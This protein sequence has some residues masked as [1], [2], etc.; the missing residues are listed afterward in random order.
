MAK[1]F[2]QRESRQPCS[3]V[4]EQPDC[5]MQEAGEAASKSS[6]LAQTT[7]PLT[8]F[9]NFFRL[10]DR[11]QNGNHVL[12]N[13]AAA[14]RLPGVLAGAL[15][16]HR[17]FA[18]S[19]QGIFHL[20]SNSGIVLLP[21]EERAGMQNCGPPSQKVM[22][23]IKLFICKIGPSSAAGRQLAPRIPGC[24]KH[25]YRQ[26]APLPLPGAAI[27]PEAPAPRT[28]RSVF[29]TRQPEAATFKMWSMRKR[30]TEERR[31][32]S[33]AL[34]SMAAS[35]AKVTGLQEI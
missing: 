20:A 7:K 27:R 12:R 34:F 33:K 29:M 19:S 15:R 13:P 17:P 3:R 14:E 21:N 18:L 30:S 11:K 2:W 31:R 32:N 6:P 10:Y 4:L 26:T 1:G 5:P 25:N 23:G 8:D 24:F 9:F 35:L 16:K 28:S 22:A